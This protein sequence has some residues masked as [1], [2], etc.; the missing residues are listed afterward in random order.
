MNVK[1]F[2]L[3]LVFSFFFP[4]LVRVLAFFYFYLCEHALKLCGLRESDF[5]TYSVCINFVFERNK[6]CQVFNL[7]ILILDPMRTH[8][9]PH[10]IIFSVRTIFSNEFVNSVYDFFLFHLT[11]F[12]YM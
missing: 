9:F 6:Y 5:N 2:K 11:I 1:N 7:Y 3:K 8:R 4:S 10:I 12:H